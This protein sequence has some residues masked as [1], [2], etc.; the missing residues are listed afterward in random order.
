MGHYERPV[1]FCKYTEY[2]CP[3]YCDYTIDGRT[4]TSD[5]FCIDN[6]YFAV[7]PHTPKDGTPASNDGVSRMNVYFSKDSCEKFLD[8]LFEETRF[9]LDCEQFFTDEKQRLVST[10]VAIDR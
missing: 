7:F 5:Y 9:A 4:V 10:S 8:K 1:H 6:I 3:V 2:Q